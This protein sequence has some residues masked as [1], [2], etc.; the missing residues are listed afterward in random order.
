SWLAMSRPELTLCHPPSTNSPERTG[1][2]NWQTRP[3]VAVSLAPA[4]YKRCSSLLSFRLGSPSSRPYLLRLIVPILERA[5][6]EIA[7]AESERQAQCNR[8]R[9]HETGEQSCDQI[10]GNS[11]LIDRDDDRERP[12]RC[13]HHVRQRL[14]INKSRLCRRPTHNATQCS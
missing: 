1:R 5:R 14:R 2:L 13:P 7:A 3:F 8:Q 4:S 9:C 10:R 6:S 12:H 11:E